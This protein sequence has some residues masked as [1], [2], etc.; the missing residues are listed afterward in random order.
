MSE[1][2]T[3]VVITEVLGSSMAMNRVLFSC[4]IRPY[5]AR[6]RRRVQARSSTCHHANFNFQISCMVPHNLGELSNRDLA[7]RKCEDDLLAVVL[8]TDS[9]RYRKLFRSSR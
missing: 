3:E 2:L 5:E 8:T 1:Q 7:K 9:S 4:W 6:T